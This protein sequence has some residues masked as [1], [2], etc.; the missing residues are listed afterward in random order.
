MQINKYAA[1]VFSL[2][3]FISLFGCAARAPVRG[4]ADRSLLKK[5]S[6]SSTLFD[7]RSRTEASRGWLGVS[8]QDVT[9]EVA[10]NLNL[11]PPTGA[12]I[13]G[14]SEDGPAARAG[15]RSGDVI[16]AVNGR[17]INN[18]STLSMI[19]ANFRVGE[20]VK[21]KAFR[22]GQERI[23]SVTIERRNENEIETAAR[24]SRSGIMA[25]EL[26]QG[27]EAPLNRSAKDDRAKNISRLSVFNFNAVNID[28]SKYGPEVTNLLTDALGKNQAF[29]IISRHDLLE[30]LTLNNLQQ[31]DNLSDIVSIGGRLGLNFIVTGRIEKKGMI[32][33]LEFI[34]ASVRDEKVIFTRKVQVAGDSNLATEVIKISD[35]ISAAIINSAH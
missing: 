35:S 29:S 32:L 8:V 6:S 11:K 15:L 14:V 28:A 18:Y 13:V 34:V 22:N 21:I 5:T 17:T 4:I 19:V 12:F 30:F 16:T 1:T 20:N 23:Y 2:L 3:L 24:D 33:A 25:Q 31:N 9:A 26:A 7:S 10:K 27:K